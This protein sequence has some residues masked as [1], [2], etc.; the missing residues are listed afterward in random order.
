MRREDRVMIGHLGRLRVR[1]DEGGRQPRDGVQ[2]VVLGVNS[3]LVGLDGAG[4]RSNDDFAFSPEL[5]ADPPQAHLT[6]V[7]NSWCGSQDLLRP[8][9][10]LWVNGVHEAAI[11]LPRGLPQDGQNRQRDQ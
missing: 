7:Q 9:D 10:E 6:D 11:D 5:M 2:K 3:Y 4:V 1:V 8:V